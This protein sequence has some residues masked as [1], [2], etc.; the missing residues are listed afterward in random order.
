MKRFSR[1]FLSSCAARSVLIALLACA[2]P[3]LPAQAGAYTFSN[4][5]AQ[6]TINAGIVLLDST[7]DT[8]SPPTSTQRGP[9]N[10]DP[11]VFYI[12]SRRVDL[13]P[14]G[15]TI[16]NPLA[17]HNVSSDVQNRWDARTR[18]SSVGTTFESNNGG[19]AYQFGQNITPSMAAYW[20]VSLNDASTQDLHQFDV[21]LINL[22]RVGALSDIAKFRP[23]EVEKLRRFVDGGGTLL[24]EDNGGGNVTDGTGTAPNANAYGPLFFSLLY[25]GGATGTAQ[26][27]S[28]QYRHP[29]ISAPY[30]LAQNELNALG[31]GFTGDYIGTAS[32]DFTPVLYDTAKNILV[33]ANTYGAGAVVVSSTGTIA[34]INDAVTAG[35]IDIG[36][37]PNSGPYCGINLQSAPTQ[38]LKFLCDIISWAGGHSH[39]H[40]NSHQTGETL[41]ALPSP[42]RSWNYVPTAPGGPGAGISS[43]APGATINGNFVYSMDSAGYL[44]AF[45][46]Y[47]YEDLDGDGKPDDGT[48]SPFNSDYATGSSCDEVWNVHTGA[49]SSAPTVAT[50]PAAATTVFVE[51][52][53]GIVKQ[54]LAST[55][56]APTPATVGP[57]SSPGL[58]AGGLAP[59]PTYYE[60]RLYAAE[61]DGSLFVNDFTSGR[62]AFGGVSVKL[63]APGSVAGAVVPT[64]SP[65]VG[66][67]ASSGPSL[68]ITPQATDIVALVPTDNG[69]YSL[70]LG[71]RGEQ[72]V[73]TA[74][75]FTA[76]HVPGNAA[77]DANAKPPLRVYT[78]TSA[79]A[80]GNGYA[81]QETYTVAPRTFAVTPATTPVFAD[82]DV[83]FAA[84]TSLT[85]T[86]VTYGASS[87]AT[88]GRGSTPALD[89]FGNAYYFASEPGATPYTVLTSFHDAHSG[90]RLPWRFRLPDTGEAVTDADGTDY[91]RLDGFQFQGK[92]VVDSRGFVYA[93][94]FNPSTS[95][96]AVLCFD[97]QA[98]VTTAPLGTDA[99]NASLTQYV[100]GTSNS[101]FGAGGS[102]RSCPASTRRTASVDR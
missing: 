91:T 52:L 79:T 94:A 13:L 85:R 100:S 26:L 57:S 56:A 53:D 17:A 19:H 27:P 9:N 95:Q 76:S 35:S 39:E 77:I 29:I 28:L 84:S 22:G 98:A 82:Y 101:E 16:K 70:F 7:T 6:R 4:P 49:G 88:T 78:L 18:N 46:L 8:S 74:S 58:F 33:G 61:P 47:P 37:G 68:G 71:A 14:V 87:T 63:I 31:N 96:T 83:D 24:V 65:L 36:Y 30:Y 34:A 38:D 3:T 99:G 41:S 81:N 55:T 62:S 32:S 92:P 10:P 73:G 5:N 12:L 80:P 54:Y 89:R 64:G 21:L 11:Y 102:A 48:V 59:A 93:L 15:W 50:P 60:G 44:H 25:A 51:G 2:V 1:P 45:D 42:V 97:G 40:Q 86:I 43:N 90:P 66:A 72:L 20:E 69:L 23:S 75:P 67:L